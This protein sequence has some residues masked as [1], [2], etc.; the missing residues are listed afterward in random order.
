MQ[1][2]L[3]LLVF[4]ALVSAS[5]PLE[6]ATRTFIA[7]LPESERSYVTSGRDRFNWLSGTLEHLMDI[8]DE[9]RASHVLGL[10][11]GWGHYLGPTSPEVNI[12]RFTWCANLF[13]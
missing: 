3:L 8:D 11:E 5:I 9:I 2:N 13:W 12:V 7:L 10:I 4:T 1:L 6:T